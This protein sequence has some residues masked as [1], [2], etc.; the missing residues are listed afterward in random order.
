MI[1]ERLEIGSANIK[2]ILIS[3]KFF[4]KGIRRSVKGT[5]ISLPN[6]RRRGISG[7]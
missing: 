2:G 4:L 3:A 5:F 7:C 1:K 6:F